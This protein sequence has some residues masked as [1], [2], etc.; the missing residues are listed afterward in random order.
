MTYQEFKRQLYY[1]LVELKAAEQTELGIL[2][3]GAVYEDAAVLR[4]IRAVN[5]ADCGREERILQ[6]DLLYAVWE[7][8]GYDC[9][10]Y[11]PV[12]QL[13]E[14]YQSEGWQGVLPELT[15]AVNRECI[16]KEGLPAEN[17]TY[18]QHRA[19]L[20]LRPI[21]YTLRYE[22]LCNCIYWKVG[23]IALVLYLLVYDSPENLLSLKLDRNLTE[24]WRKRDTVLL[25]GA[26]LNCFSRMPPRLYP[27]QDMLSYYDERGGVFMPGDEGIPAVI[28]NKDRMQGIIGYR[29]TTTRRLNGAVAIFYPGVKERL[30]ELLEGDYYVGFT[31]VNEAV[32]HPIRYK[33]L[34]DMK[35]AIYHNN[36]MLDR[37]NV[38]TSKVYRYVQVRSE[39]IE[40]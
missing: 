13:Y 21:A 8:G 19:N 6:E 31:S 36:A 26:L 5:L 37:A 27:G 15:A 9:M 28:D 38:L 12:R 35:A 20:I 11:W 16:K 25:T 4:V 10:L 24:K 30:A 14:R 29:L 40:V 2:E 3:K 1:S 34:Q 23:D 33:R 17:D 39:L 7:K 18:I 22:E 32:I